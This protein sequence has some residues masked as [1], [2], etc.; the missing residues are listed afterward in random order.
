MSAVNNFPAVREVCLN[1]DE[2]FVSHNLP[3]VW[4]AISYLISWSYGA[5]EKCHVQIYND[6]HGELSAV[7]RNEQGNVT[8]VIEAVPREDGSFSYHS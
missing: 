7:Y 5:P 4:G 3:N 1:V 6:R 2:E 8:Y